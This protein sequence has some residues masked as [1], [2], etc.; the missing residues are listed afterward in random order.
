M[1]S[2]AL[3]LPTP[4][5]DAGITRAVGLAGGAVGVAGTVGTIYL[6]APRVDVLASRPGERVNMLSLIARRMRVRGGI[7]LMSYL[8][9]GFAAG[10][11]Y[12]V[13]QSTLR[14][15]ATSGAAA[16]AAPPPPAPS[17]DMTPVPPELAAVVRAPITTQTVASMNNAEEAHSAAGAAV[18]V[19]TATYESLPDH[20]LNGAHTDAP[21]EHS[22]RSEYFAEDSSQANEEPSM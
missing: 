7:L 2:V 10:A 4:Q 18:A 13:A 5:E 11:G 14:P 3:A 20:F 19:P 12:A 22:T 6:T 1:Q 9:T 21:I 16:I 8:W 15:A 17:T